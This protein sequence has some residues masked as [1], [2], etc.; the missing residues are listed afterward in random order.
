[1]LS[2]S[3]PLHGVG[4]A[5]YYLRLAQKDYYL[6]EGFGIEVEH[7]E[8][9]T[10]TLKIP[11]VHELEDID[12]MRVPD[13]RKDGRMPVYLEAISRLAEMTRLRSGGCHTEGKY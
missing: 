7:C 11:V 2:I 5:D 1:M 6:A 13:P 10:P 3:L 8:D 12:T 9:S 4:H